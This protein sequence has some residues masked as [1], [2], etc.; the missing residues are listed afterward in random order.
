MGGGGTRCVC[1]F[2]LI[3]HVLKMRQ[4]DC[5][6]CQSA[7]KH[8]HPSRIL[9][10]S[11]D[12]VELQTDGG[13]ASSAMQTAADLRDLADG[14]SLCSLSSVRLTGNDR[15]PK[16]RTVSHPPLPPPLLLRQFHESNNTKSE[17]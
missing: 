4:H 5:A 6:V 11:H 17:W 2:F 12:H 1:L 8:H 7:H 13:T 15:T 3:F 9:L 16:K 10:C 14:L